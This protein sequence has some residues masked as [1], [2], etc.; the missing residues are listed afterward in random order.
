MTWANYTLLLFGLSWAFTGIYRRHALS[1]GYVDQPNVR[2]SHTVVTP[3]GG[4]IVFSMMWIILL[5]FASYFKW[6]PM[7]QLYVFLPA[8]LVALLGFKDDMK[9]ISAKSRLMVQTLACIL[10][11]YLLKLPNEPIVF[12]LALPNVELIQGFT[13]NYAVVMTCTVLGMLWM[14]NLMNF[15]DGTDGL[16]ATQAIIVLGFA[17]VVLY[18]SGGY[19][20]AVLC[21]GACSLILGFLT[22]NWPSANIFMGDSGSGFLGFLIALMA[23]SA[24]KWFNIPYGLWVILT[25]PFWF[26]ATVTLLRRMVKGDRWMEAHCMHAYQRLTH[27][28]WSH[29]QVLC[30]AIAVNCVTVWMAWIAFKQPQYLTMLMSMAVTFMAVIYL[31]IEI[32]KPMYKTWH[33]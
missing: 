31:M 4:G 7:Q 8:G 18:Q 2:S 16:C 15:M 20:L 29:L 22:W 11:L 33:A 21:I 24:H 5:G 12:G 13:L 26:D 28:G 27:V 9:S 1:K 30:C 6:I 14:T 23:V 32:H 17:G 3:R 25:C 19:S 10:S